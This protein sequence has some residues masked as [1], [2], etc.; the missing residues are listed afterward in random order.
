M[1]LS[2]NELLSLSLAFMASGFILL[3]YGMVQG[4]LFIGPSVMFLLFFISLKIKTRD[5]VKLYSDL[6]KEE[7][8]LQFG[9]GITPDLKGRRMAALKEEAYST[10]PIYGM[11]PY[12]SYGPAYGPAA[13]S[14]C[15]P[16][17]CGNFVSYA[18]NFKKSVASRLAY[19]KDLASGIFINEKNPQKVLEKARYADFGSFLEYAT[20]RLLSSKFKQN[21]ALNIVTCGKYE[22]EEFC[23]LISTFSRKGALCLIMFESK[24]LVLHDAE[25]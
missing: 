20:P 13:Y 19:E 11:P 14:D 24:R 8:Y 10:N 3:Q 23:S 15:T 16:I 12:E 4:L 1:N 21:G 5:S 7:R 17:A 25:T 18:K 22:Y 2:S 9:D 6:D